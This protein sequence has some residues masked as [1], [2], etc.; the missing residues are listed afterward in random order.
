MCFAVHGTA[1]GREPTQS[2]LLWYWYSEFN[3]RDWFF[4]HRLQSRPSQE[5]LTVQLFSIDKKQ[6]VLFVQ[7]TVV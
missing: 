7:F 5:M 1:L 2:S 4:R 3:W 6:L